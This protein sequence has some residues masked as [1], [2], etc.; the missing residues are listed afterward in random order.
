M[1][2]KGTWITDYVRMIRASKDKDWNQYLTPDD[3]DI[4]NGKVLSS[5]WYPYESFLR[6]GKAVFREIA[7]KNL[8]VSRAFGKMFAD[9]IA[10]VY[11]NIVI[12]GEPAAS[13]SKVYALQGTFFR[14]IPS[15]IVPMLHEKNRTVVK[16]N[17]TSR[18]REFSEPEAF[19][20]QFRGMMERLLEKVGVKKYESEVR[21]VDDGYEVELRWE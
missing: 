11:K 4:I 17:V 3:W 12:P 5:S 6:I 1:E 10:N 2:V 21:T 18:E 20:H 8:E 7:R 14:D 9:N 13:I 15:I 16:I 19:A